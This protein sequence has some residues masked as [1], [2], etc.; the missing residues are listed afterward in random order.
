MYRK[1]TIRNLI[2]LPIL[3]AQT[4]VVQTMAHADNFSTIIER[5]R[6]VLQNTAAPAPAT[7]QTW[8]ANLDAN[9]QW[10]DIDYTNV[11]KGVWRVASHLDRILGLSR[12]LTDS[13]HALYN[14]PKA[15]ATVD[16]AL[17]HW[18]AKK[19][20][21]PNWWHNDIGVPQ[22]VRDFLVLWGE[23]L[24]PE[25]RTATLQL[26]KE[27]YKPTKAGDGQNTVWIAELGLVYGALTQ[28]EA[29]VKQNSQLISGEIHIS[30][31]EGIQ[32]DF[33]FHQHTARLQQF[34]YGGAFTQDTARL[35]WELRG[36]PWA[37]PVE[38]TQILGNYLF[39]GS[40][41][42][43]R[44][45]YTVPGTMDRSVSRQNSLRG[46][47]LRR[48]AN[49]LRE[50]L[51]ERAAEAD[52]LIARQN[53]TGTPLTGFRAFP[54][55]DFTTY[56]QPAFS[57]FVKTVSDRT[58]TTEIGLNSENLK[59]HWLGCGDHYLLR[60]GLEYYN[61]PAV[62]DW[63]LLPG[64]THSKDGGTIQRM[65]FVGAVGNENSGV[66]AMDYRTADKQNHGLSARKLWACSGD[67]VVCLIGGLKSTGTQ[68]PVR[69]ALDQCLLRGPVTIADTQN[70][71]RTLSD[72]NYDSLPIRWIHHAGMLYQPLGNLPVTLRVGP[73]S[74]SWADFNKSQSSQTVTMPVFLPVLEQGTAPKDQAS[75]FVLTSC[76]T[77]QEASNL[78]ARPTWEVLRNDTACQAVR[79]VDGSVMAAFYEAGQLEEKGKVLLKVD[80]PALLMVQK[81]KLLACDPTQ[82]GGPLQMQSSDGKALSLTL[83]AGGLTVSSP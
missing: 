51:P 17:D 52:A 31:G 75:G 79:F 55:S 57:F 24:T 26:Y 63:D 82:K 68:E 3:V 34:H 58:L 6:Q 39:N 56:H 60:D 7:L 32:S 21:N 77:P 38:K 71:T 73:V 76:A 74:G 37:F 50:V 62:W 12:A 30:K 83:P 35:A 44:G 54:R 43:V 42:M 48:A 66:T 20:K 78:T 14:D 40:Q 18:L 25:R 47:D 4:L 53:G 80:Q 61:L 29:L 28:D 69:T 1:H 10:P 67:V 59:G 64:I 46:G 11:D 15:S 2:L 5:Y 70:H 13:K 45:T 41:W 16:R 81:G 49:Y 72:G 33:S 9:G 19:Y 23:H 27:Q 8:I 65:P 22:L 36:T